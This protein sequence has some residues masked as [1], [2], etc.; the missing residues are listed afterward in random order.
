M[1][2]SLKFSLKSEKIAL[3]AVSQFKRQEGLLLAL[4]VLFL[5][6]GVL[7]LPRRYFFLGRL[8]IRGKITNSILLIISSKSVTK[9]FKKNQGSG[10]KASSVVGID[11]LPP[12]CSHEE[13]TTLRVA[14][15]LSGRE[16]SKISFTTVSQIFQ[17][18]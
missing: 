14:E 11:L 17:C 9:R 2:M 10:K 12:V 5:I 16:V 3:D 8:F 1:L 18:S 7:S 15:K 13:S 6:H 4:L